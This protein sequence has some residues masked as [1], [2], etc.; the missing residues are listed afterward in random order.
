MYRPYYLVLIPRQIPTCTWNTLSHIILSLFLDLHVQTILSHP[1]FQNHRTHYSILSLPHSYTHTEH[2]IS[3]Y[4]ILI[5]RLTD[6]IISSS[7]SHPHRTH[8]FLL[9]HPHSQT[10]R[11]HYLFLIL[12]PTQNTL[13]PIIS[14]S[15]PDSQTTL[16]LPHPHRTHYLL[17]SHPHSQTYTDSM[18]LYIIMYIT[19]IKT[20]SN[21]YMSI[22][23][24]SR[25]YLIR[26]WN[27]RS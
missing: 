16:S 25:N 8:Y 14:S 15:F 22:I 1:H 13:S 18:M 6:H 19:P 2:I 26:T 3:Y 23:N 20:N 11:P 4:L 7:L 9:S 27:N 24:S 5:P 12:T 10:H 17:L 21:L